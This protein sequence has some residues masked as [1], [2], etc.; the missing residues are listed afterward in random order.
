MKSIG[1]AID[2][3]KNEKN[4]LTFTVTQCYIIIPKT[5]LPMKF[6]LSFTFLCIL[7]LN[8]SNFAQLSSSN[9]P[10]ISIDTDNEDIP[11]EPKLFG[12]MGIIYDESGGINSINDHF[13]H[14][15]GYV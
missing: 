11:D 1:K 12:S 3:K 14:Y 10:I 5:P 8:Q 2:D 9:L 13:N 4:V 6:K 15:D 7:L